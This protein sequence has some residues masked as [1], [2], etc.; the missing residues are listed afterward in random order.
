MYK[1]M[2]DIADSIIHILKP[3]VRCDYIYSEASA[4]ADEIGMGTYFMRLGGEAKKVTFIGHG[5]GIELNEPPLLGKNSQEV[6][7]EGMIIALEL[8]MSSSVGEVVKLEDTLLI[9]SDG[10]EILTITPRDLHQV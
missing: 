10:A 6:L 1:G 5:V 4:Y 7:E 8:V 2:K 9:T 3:G